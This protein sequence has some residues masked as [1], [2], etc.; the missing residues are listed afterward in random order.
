MLATVN[1]L[2]SL[3]EISKTSARRIAYLQAAAMKFDA[4]VIAD[5]IYNITATEAKEAMNTVKKLFES[6]RI[7]IGYQSADSL[8]L[9][10]LYHEMPYSIDGGNCKKAIRTINTAL[11][12]KMMTN[13]LR[14]S[15]DKQLIVATAFASICNELGAVKTKLIKGRVPKASDINT[16][17]NHVGSKA[18][19]ELIT[20]K[21]TEIT[22]N[23]L[24]QF[25]AGQTASYQL[26][27]D[28]VRRG[29]ASIAA[30]NLTPDSSRAL[31]SCFDFTITGHG[32]DKVYTNIQETAAAST[33]AAEQGA[34]AR[35]TASQNFL[36][37][38]AQ[39]LSNIVDRKN[40]MA[41]VTGSADCI[42][43]VVTA[44]LFFSFADG[45]AFSAKNKV[46]INST[47]RGDRF[48]QFPS[49]FHEVILVNGDTLAFPSEEKMIKVFSA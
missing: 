49:T 19:V 29:G 38:A 6:V 45:S 41:S 27:I 16:F 24:D 28:A 37:K 23:P 30:N 44:Y 4:E 18:S 8:A 25:E 5:K 39:K 13:E 17:T 42:R 46:I 31:A 26:D 10:D 7:T 14:L 21:L 48:Y 36:H 40:N 33:Y 43:G 12:V 1:S 32:K 2:N 35:K 34:K 15:L 3:F 9:G 11:Q 47:A 22:K 20:A